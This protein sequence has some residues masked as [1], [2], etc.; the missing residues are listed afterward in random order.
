[1]SSQAAN[2]TLTIEATSSDE[3]IQL[4]AEHFGVEPERLRAEVIDKAGGG[5]FRRGPPRLQVRVAVVRDAAPAETETP[6]P[7]RWMAALVDNALEILITSAEHGGAPVDPET[8]LAFISALGI[9]ESLEAST[10]AQLASTVGR[11]VLI[12]VETLGEKRRPS[13]TFHESACVVVA[14]D[15]LSAWLVSPSLDPTHTVRSADV[16]AALETAGVTWGIQEELVRR[17]DG[18]RVVRPLP[19]AKGRARQEGRNAEIEHTIE[20][21][22]DDQAAD[23]APTVDYRARSHAT[24]VAAGTLIARKIPATPAVTGMNVR[25]EELPAKDGNDIDLAALA[26]KNTEVQDL[27]E[28][29][30]AALVASV[31]GNVR[32][33]GRKIEVEGVLVLQQDVDF[34]S[35]NIDFPGPVTVRGDVASGFVLRAAGEVQIAGNVDGATVI[36][37]GDVTVQGGFLAEAEGH[38]GRIESGGT[39]RVGFVE[40][41]VVVARGDVVVA[42]ELM[43]SRVQAG[44]SVRVE[45]AGRIRGGH[46]VA[47]RDV[48]AGAI[49]SPIG[50]STVVAA[51][52]SGLPANV[53]D[54][55]RE[56]H[57]ST[58]PTPDLAESQTGSGETEPDASSPESAEPHTDSDAGDAGSNAAPPESADSGDASPPTD[59]S[60]PRVVATECIEAGTVVIVGRSL[61]RP[62]T[63]MHHCQLVEQA[64]TVVVLPL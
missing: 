45:G 28:V 63:R 1:M 10:R 60:R 58:Q 56:D 48:R 8:I 26:G 32:H 37:E 2:Q 30:D 57:R 51:G 6:Q 27:D 38:H 31:S 19:I 59:D 55:L 25:G 20:D 17:V 49:G 53:S 13:A 5:L 52:C 3:A 44:G 15:A 54:L 35:G 62:E 36:A 18:L 11:T 39:V 16:S 7:G 43:R 29:P 46:V 12:P 61:L 42:R 21:A 64:G 23:D 14:E 40:G 22:S 50:T 9:T 24:Y 41:G 47:Y 33:K 4:A 34:R